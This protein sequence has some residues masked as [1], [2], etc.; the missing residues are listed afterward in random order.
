MKNNISRNPFTLIFGQKPLQYISRIKQSNEIIDNMIEDFCA[1]NMI[2]GVRGSGKTVMMTSIMQ[3]MSEYDNWITMELNP[4]RDLLQGFAAKLYDEPNIQK[5]FIKSKINLTAFGIGV[6]IENTAPISDIEIALERRL[7]QVKKAGKKI[8]IA[9][10]EV[11]NSENARIFISAYQIFL[12]QNYP[13]CL[14]MTGLYD[15][16]YNLQND[17]SMTFLYRAPKILLEPLNFTSVRE[18]YRQIFNISEEE[19]SRMAYTTKGFSFAFQV[20]GYLYWENRNDM[21]LE[22]LMPKYD[23]YLAEYVYDK[24]WS[25][26]SETDKKIISALSSTSGEIQVKDLRA[27]LDNMSPEKFSVYRERL[28]RKGLIN[29]SSYGKLSLSLPRFEEYTKNRMYEW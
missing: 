6:E 7:D 2:T 5:L 27:K 12:R 3:R 26:L 16:I 20:L 9:I 28:K 8:L 4:Q 13:I 15:N 11:T 29:V 1:V 10:D 24:I 23:Q 14:L 17:K 19:A 21:T 22:Q 25:E 18:Q